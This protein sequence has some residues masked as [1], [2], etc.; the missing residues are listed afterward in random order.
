MALAALT[1]ISSLAIAPAQ[2]ANWSDTSVGVRYVSDQ[3][4]P[5]V[6]DS[7]SKN[8]MTFTHVSGD[9]LGSNFFTIDLLKSSSVD[10]S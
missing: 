3:S 6:T 7:V 5:G 8:V 2:A 10:P 9:N 1:A 4:E